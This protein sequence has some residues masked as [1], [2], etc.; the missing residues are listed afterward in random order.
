MADDSRDPA[1]GRF[2]PGKSGNPSG[3]RKDSAAS[4]LPDYIPTE[5]PA[6]PPAGHRPPPIV[7]EDLP[8]ERLDSWVSA[9]TGIGTRAYDKRESSEFQVRSLSYLEAINLWRGDD[10]ASRAITMI[11]AD[12]FSHGYDVEFPNETTYGSLR[13]DV[14][15][16][17]EELKVD[18]LVER[19]FCYERAF[20]GGAILL[21]VNDGRKLSEPLDPSSVKSLDYLTVLEPIEI[22]P[23]R[24][25]EDPSAPKYG[26]PEYYRLVSFTVSG[27]GTVVG[28]TDRRAPVPSTA[29]IHESRLVVFGGTRV[30]RFQRNDSLMGPLW[31]DSVLIKLVEILRDFNVAWS[32]AGLLATDFAQSVISV[33][34]LMMLVAKHP[35]KVQARM[36][37]FELQ[38]STARAILIDSKE[39]FQR[40]TTSLASFPELLDR[41]SLRLAAALDTP[42]YKLF[43]HSPAGLGNASDAERKDW[44]GRV[45]SVQRRKIKPVIRFFVKL[46][47]QTLR[48]RKLPPK[49]K[50][51]FRDL[52][53]LSD[54]ELEQKYLTR[55]RTFSMITKMGAAWPDEIRRDLAKDFPTIDPSKKAPGFIAPLPAGVLPKA[56]AAPAEITSIEA[57]EK[58]P[59]P[60]AQPPAGAGPNVH[61]VGGYARRNPQQP[62]LE[63][64]PKQGGDAA[65]NDARRARRD[66]D[67]PGEARTFAGLPVVIESPRGSK[68]R[69]VDVDGTVG[70][71]RMLHDYGYI[72]RVGGADG[73]SVDVYLGPN[74]DAENAYIVH[75][76]KPPDFC[77]Y[78]EDKVMLGFDS[79]NHARDAYLAHRDDD[80]AYAG[81]AAM[82]M[83]RFRE[84]FAPKSHS[85][86]DERMDRI[87]HREGK[88]VVTDESGK[89]VL[90]THATREE[91]IAQLAAIEESKKR[92]ENEDE[93]T[94][95]FED[96]DPAEQ[97]AL[98]RVG[99]RRAVDN[100]LW[101]A[102][103]QTTDLGDE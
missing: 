35:D 83:D 17:L 42:I 54:M 95:G 51:K 86:G 9:T 88:W 30:S 20:G 7:P 43:G 26:E 91:A 13:D 46:I 24:Y 22:Y 31:G 63:P 37:A 47:I 60:G 29:L 6:P 45:R 4:M 94:G 101:N 14:E 8:V 52:E 38:R 81:M 74:E 77:F 93:I 67:G 49:V 68:R 78:D 66:A 56:M 19:V 89:E 23:E 80:R 97:L 69:W 12:C 44:N 82:P 92:R 64:D 79:A 2:V 25:Y 98:P 36:R 27:A 96:A 70:H 102:T 50:I 10:L 55:T 99:E 5:V 41:L 1:T 11:P 72:P 18:E 15:E 21:G 58:R 76:N 100:P 61:V 75:Q 65:P 48:K 16:R 57:G 62:A 59:Q 84:L 34:N 3:V 85:D 71:T 40:E 73:D 103:L 32:S 39:K 87:F 28:V 90:G 53:Q 33:E